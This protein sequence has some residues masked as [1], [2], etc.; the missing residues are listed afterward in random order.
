MWEA[1]EDRERFAREHPEVLI[2]PRRDGGRLL[3][4]VSAPDFA[5][6][7]YDN[8]VVMLADLRRRYPAG[9]PWHPPTP[10]EEDDM[11]AKADDRCSVCGFFNCICPPKQPR[12]P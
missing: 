5:A 12:Q 11:K 6:M 8:P 4:D 10:R 3:F 1:V 2:M 9:P 7:G